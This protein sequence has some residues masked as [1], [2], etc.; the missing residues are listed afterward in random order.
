MPKNKTHDAIIIGGGIAGA[1]IAYFLTQKGMRDILILEKEEQPGYHSTGRAVGVLAEFDLIPSMVDLKILGG[2]FLRNPPE[3]FSEYPLLRKSG[4]LLLGQGRIWDTLVKMIPELKSKGVEIQV[5][6]RDDARLIVPFVSPEYIDGALLFSEDGHI[7]VHELLWGYL[8]NARKAGAEL[9]CGEEVQGIKVES[10]KVVGI[11]SSKNEYSCHWVINA[12]GAWVQKIR[13][14]AG[15]S[16]I[17]LTPFRR[18]IITFNAPDG[19]NVSKWPLT[20][21]QTH[22]FYL[23]PESGGLLASPMDEEPMEPCDARPD[24]IV[25]AQTIER[26]KQFT[27]QIL[28]KA[29]KQKWAGLRTF[30]SDQSMVIGEDPFLKGFFWL[31]GQGGAGIET[32]GV[33]GHIAADLII[34]GCTDIMDVSQFVPER[35][36]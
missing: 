8:R 28:P 27:P 20:A 4:I 34:D 16:P 35:F 12:A 22:K 26:L 3:N 19:F 18:T 29:I 10:S 24:E 33:V 13:S 17:K 21:D 2:K 25:V 32:S 1:S 5:L 30:S 23:S 36:Y 11:I 6:S 31:A 9:R 7:D 14:L 15:P